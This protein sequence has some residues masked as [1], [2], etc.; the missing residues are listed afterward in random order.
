[1]KS[2]N[3]LLFATTIYSLFKSGVTLWLY[4]VS[5]LFLSPRPLGSYP[6]L[7]LTEHEIH[8]IHQHLSPE[9]NLHNK[10]SNSSDFSL[11]GIVYVDATHWSL[12]LNKRMIRP[13]NLHQIK[14]V[15]IEK[16]TPLM[17]KFSWFPPHSTL[18]ILFTLRPNQIYLGKENRVVFSKYFKK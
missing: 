17:V 18:P 2:I 6:S 14:G 13:D 3:N 12:W 8:L 15:N 4:A 11:S 16:V 5:V 7:L 1:M 10:D 9:N